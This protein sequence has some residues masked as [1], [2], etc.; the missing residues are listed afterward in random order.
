MPL[1][2]LLSTAVLS[3]ASAPSTPLGPFEDR[4]IAWTT[5]VTL[6]GFVGLIALS[7]LSAGPPARRIGTGTLTIVTTRLAGLAIVLGLLAVPAVLTE[8][9][10]NASD[11]GGYDYRAAWNLLYDGSNAGRLAG[12]EVT[13]SLVGAALIAPLVSRVGAAG[14]ARNCLLGGGLAAGAVALGTTKFPAAVPTDWPRTSFKT[15]MWMLHLFGGAIWIG[16]LAGL[17]LLAAPGAVGAADRGAFWSPTIRRFS[18]VAMS[19]VAAITL[20]GLFLYWEHVDGPSQLF[21]TM[22]GRVLGVKI[23][24]FGTLLL[25][26]IANQFWLHP[27]IEALRAAGDQR[28]LRV[29][30]VREFRAIIAV[31][32]LLGLTVLFVAPFLRGSARNQAFQANA[33]EHATA[34]TGKLPKIATKDVSGATWAWGIT[35]TIVVIAIMAAGYYL[36]GRL[37]RR[38]AGAPVST[39]APTASVVDS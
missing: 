10:H 27:R 16:G 12:L 18:A 2:S 34:G 38:R 31:E 13:F 7:L 20:S 22:Y 33:A 17:L 5:W 35:E 36:S 32:F 24:I 11:S 6:M 3:A 23:L 29:L 21:T 30:L 26:G 9:A 19:C 4:A 1:P 8:L 15:V 39:V 28:P 37:A 25:L 14:R